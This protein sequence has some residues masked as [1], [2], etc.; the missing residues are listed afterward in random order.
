MA[1]PSIPPEIVVDGPPFPT[2]AGTTDKTQYLI[3]ADTWGQYQP[4][5]NS[6]MNDVAQNVSDNSNITYN[7]ALIA[8]NAAGLTKYKGDYDAPT[9]Y[10]QGESVTSGGIFWIS[11]V[12]SNQGNTPA[13][14]A[15]WEKV[16][17]T[18]VVVQTTG[19]DLDWSQEDVL[20]FTATADFEV[21][22]SNIPVS[23]VALVE[24]KGGG[25]WTPTYPTG[26][27]FDGGVEPT[28]ATGTDTTVLV[29]YTST[30]GT[31]I[32]VSTQMGSVAL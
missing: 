26:T 1:T 7:N 20:K 22:F 28:L 12:D 4:T 18:A 3:D 14:G 24:I 10:A 9:T 2:R 8:A 6:E 19:F 11:K 29:F 25:D 21:T 5:R 30:T 23:G 16:E 17:T 15:F 27:V 13:Q 32:G 31:T